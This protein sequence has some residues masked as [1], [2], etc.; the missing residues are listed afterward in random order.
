MRRDEKQ[1][2]DKAEIDAIIRSS[3]TCRLAMSDGNRPYVIPLCFGYD[4]STLYFHCAPEG[5]KVDILREN[6]QV[7]VEFD[8]TGDVDEAECACSWGIRFQSVV[9]FGTALPV[10]EPEEKRKGLAL[11]MSQY[12]RPGQE[13]SFPDASVSRT[14]V[15][16]VVIDEMTGKQSR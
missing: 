2:T 15:I 5:M 7:C 9:A 8:I 1:I 10:K 11:L 14:T 3:R 12:S 13:F 16:K 6:P 4:G